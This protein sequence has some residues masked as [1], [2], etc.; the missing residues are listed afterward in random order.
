M[1]L[2]C[3]HRPIMAAKHTLIWAKIAVVEPIYVADYCFG[4]NVKLPP[5]TGYFS[6]YQ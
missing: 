6:N 5:V 2:T 3:G 4:S 1:S